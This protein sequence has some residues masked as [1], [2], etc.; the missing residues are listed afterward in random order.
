MNAM[1]RPNYFLICQN[2]TARTRSTG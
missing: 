2:S 1:S